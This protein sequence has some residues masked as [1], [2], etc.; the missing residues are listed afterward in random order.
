MNAQDLKNSILQLA[1][2]GKLVEQRAEEG[3]AREL[4]EQIK[5]EK[6]Q[7]IK[8][9]KIKKSK[10]LPEITEDEIPF[11]IP[12]SWE[13]MR[14]GD[15]GSWSAGAT[16][17]RQHPEYY[18]GEIPWLK[19]G[20]LNDGYITDIPEFVGQLALEK[21]SLR[22]NPIG[23]VLMAMYGATIG[24][25]GILKIEATTNQACCACIPYSCIENKYLFFYLMSQRK[26]YISMGAGGAQP[27]IS[28]EKIVMSL[29]PVPPL[30]EQKRIV[31]KIEEILPYI[32]QYDKAYTKLETFNKKFPE[33]MKKS[34]LQMAMQG[35]LVEQ[36]AEEGT[37][38]ELYEQIVAEKAQ[39]IKD[40]K[41]KKEKPLPEIAE[42]E[43]PFEIPSSWKWVRFSE[44]MDVR[45]GTHDSPKYIETGIP[46][47]TSK[48]ISGGG[49][50]FSN[51]KYI[52]REDADKINERS[53]VDT[54]DILFAM[55]GSIGNPVIVNKDREFC[56][57]NVAL[58]K[59]YDKSKMCI[60]YVYWFLYREQY[61][62]KKVASGGVQSFISLRVF[63]NYLFPL[64]PLE[65]QKRIVA[66]IE[67]LLP[68]CD[69]LIK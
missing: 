34:I 43:I 55:I 42:D 49:L 11:E 23:S 18:E 58:F 31:A 60:E 2:Q 32:D 68:Y 46:L 65:E 24:K 14:V 48:N 57:K 19:T 36:R 67:E 8:D 40:G 54:G 51:V 29:I 41:I 59:N 50:D 17:S 66:K 28:K 52:S 37:A 10:P 15:V 30:D 56:V 26:N 35:K 9:K 3:T 38:D 61:I 33:Y 21:T 39:L 63:R 53:N 1:V 62:M 4:L 13:W 69:Q 12:E 6:D 22:L 27:N 64:P 25:L 7:L 44:V 47:V 45:D 16:P 5:L 20:D